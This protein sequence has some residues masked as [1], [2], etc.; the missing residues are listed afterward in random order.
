MNVRG[1]EGK[2]FVVES[3]ASVVRDDNLAAMKSQPGD[4][5]PPGKQVGDLKVIPQRT[6][7]GE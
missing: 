5:I 1:Y 4:D 7:G 3:S 6:A 2:V